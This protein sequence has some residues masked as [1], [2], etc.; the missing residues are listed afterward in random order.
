MLATLSGLFCQ[1]GSRQQFFHHISSLQTAHEC[2][3]WWQSHT[4]SVVT[5]TEK[6]CVHNKRTVSVCDKHSGPVLT[7]ESAGR[8]MSGMRQSRQQTLSLKHRWEWEEGAEAHEAAARA[9]LSSERLKRRERQLWCQTS[10]QRPET[11]WAEV[12][13]TFLPRCEAAGSTHWN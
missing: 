11:V 10:K 6:C 12:T 2:S 13:E 9:G 8:G 1:G 4:R 3:R 7:G 5:K